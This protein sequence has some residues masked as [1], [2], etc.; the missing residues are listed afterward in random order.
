MTDTVRNLP[1]SVTVLIGEL[2]TARGIEVRHVRPREG[3]VETRWFETGT[4]RT[5]GSMSRDTDSVVRMRF[6]TDPVG[7]EQT[8][9]V[10]EA[11][12]RRVL[13]PSLPERETEAPVPTEHPA[14]EIVRGIL[15]DVRQHS[16]S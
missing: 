6:W 12:H 11:V 7:E 15:A 4:L 16:A 10:G 5:V 14:V 1:D 8:I 3:Y 13:D 2:L 9:V